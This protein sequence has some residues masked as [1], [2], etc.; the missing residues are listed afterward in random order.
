M[1]YLPSINSVQYTQ[2]IL[3]PVKSRIGPSVDLL[4]NY[5]F[6]GIRVRFGVTYRVRV[7][8]WVICFRDSFSIFIRAHHAVLQA[9]R[10]AP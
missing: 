2:R 7:N 1:N 10:S 8:V 4:G 5:M 9:N 3:Q 6:A